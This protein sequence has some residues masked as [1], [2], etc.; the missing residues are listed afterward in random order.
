MLLDNPKDLKAWKREVLRDVRRHLSRRD[1]LK[2]AAVGAGL[3]A[4]GGLLFGRKAQA[5]PASEPARPQPAT[6]VS[7]G[8]LTPPKAVT[9]G[10]FY[11]PRVMFHVKDE[12]GDQWN[13]D[14]VGD[15]ILRRRLADLTNVNVSQDPVV[16]RLAD[17]DHMCRYP[18]VFMTSEGY[19]QL[20]KNE[21]AN[22]KEFL[23]RGGFCHADDCVFQ[24]QDRFF[25]DYVKL[26][27]RLFPDNPMRLIPKDH[28]LYHCYFDLPDGAVYC[29]GEKGVGGDWGLFEKGTGR[30]MTFASA[31]DIHCG[32]MSKYFTPEKNEAALRMGVN[33]IIY[34]LTH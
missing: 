12:T 15:A 25:H 28:E 14:P 2:A 18:F 13:T 11:F 4:G 19:F 17:I 20:P 31:G 6:T 27:N 5:Q 24:N 9:T 33:I 10:T 34:Y 7:G 21:E 8:G 22:L 29:Q 26:I 32:W 16:V 30:L 3:L 1:M 23:S